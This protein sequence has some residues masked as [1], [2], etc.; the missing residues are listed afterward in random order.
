MKVALVSGRGAGAID[1]VLQDLQFGLQQVRPEW[2]VDLVRFAGK[3]YADLGFDGY[4]VVHLGYAA[5]TLVK[6]LAFDVPLTSNVW[7]VVPSRLPYFRDLLSPIGFARIIVDD[8][9]SLQMLGQAGFTQITPIPMAFNPD[10][11]SRLSPPEVPF[12][13]GCFGEDTNEKRFDIV[14]RACREA[15]VLCYMMVPPVDRKVFLLD[16]VEDV[17]SQIHVLAHASFLD[18][19]CRPGLEALAC[20]V[21]VLSTLN[22]GM[23]RVSN[24]GNVTFYDGSVQDLATK[25]RE[26]KGKYNWHRECA[27]YTSFPSLEM[28]A[29]KY[30]EVF[31]KIVEEAQ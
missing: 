1:W 16:P 29:L 26:V 20:G 18:T 17:Y 23:R 10:R 27:A 9:G 12:T 13:V 8:I 21:P 19:N 25:I 6:G 15:E 24:G 14:R 30:V 5:Y 7:H 28:I 31:E 11:Y 2:T 22:E 3:V 4:D